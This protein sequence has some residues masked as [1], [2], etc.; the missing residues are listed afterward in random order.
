[1]KNNTRESGWEGVT[2]NSTELRERIG[3]AMK[4]AATLVI[5]N[6]HV[7]NVF[8]REVTLADV[9][10][11]EDT[12]I[13][14][15]E[16]SCDNE[17]DAKGV[18]LCPGFIDAHVHIESSMVTPNS[19]ARVVLPHGTTAIIA[20]PHE[21]ANV[22]GTEGIWAMYKMSNMM[23]LWVYFM[24]P[25]CVPATPFDNTGA[26]ILADDMRQLKQK[27]RMLGLGEVMDYVSTTR[28]E[29]SMLEKLVLFEDMRID[30]HAPLL[31]GNALNAYCVAGP[32]TD[33]ECSCFDEVLE[34]L[35][36]GMS[37]LIRVGSAANGVREMLTEIA[38]RGLPTDNMMFC[39]DD[40][41][42]ENTL[43]E[44]HINCIARL[45][46]EC[47]IAPVD[48]VRMAS[49]N[50]AR[51]YGLKRQG[52]IAPGYRATM[53]LF[54]NLRDFNVVDV[55]AMGRRYE[56]TACDIGHIL[57]ADVLNTINCAPVSARDLSLRRDVLGANARADGLFPVIRTIPGQL[58]TEL[59]YERLR[60]EDGEFAA[61]ERF[62]KLAV[63]ERH[64]ATGNVGV[65]VVEG[66][67]LKDGAICASVAHDSHNIVVVGDN[68]EDMLLAVESLVECGGGFA[69]VHRGIVLARLPLPIAGLMTDAPVEEV[70]RKQRALVDAAKLLGAPDESDPLVLL[71][72]LALPVIPNVRL[73]DEG[74]IDVGKTEYI[75]KNKA[76]GE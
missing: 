1:M 2:V 64:H 18:Y 75:Y 56:D 50:A 13:G 6:A 63:I 28:C 39:T 38:D 47:G 19:F 34:K 52:A 20:D 45:A 62:N 74:L 17:Y 14:V 33:H 10:V 55:F 31:S 40:K 48:A 61:D 9:A 41:H 8:T 76:K 70:L 49:Y 68:D 37:I 15:G 65:G 24:M 30:G 66:L 46:V 51:A 32:S 69:V 53:V 42:L 5:K 57:P 73:T 16:Y 35:R 72:F 36:A 4:G 3:A 44:G 26:R 71:S 23:P 11:Y 22:C 7:V 12:I 21:I 60:F 27:S 29:E 58:V 25:S 67:Q 54:D 59:K 43:R